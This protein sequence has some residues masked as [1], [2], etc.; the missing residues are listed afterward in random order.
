MSSNQAK[1]PSTVAAYQRGACLLIPDGAKRL[2]DTARKLLK[3]KGN[4][5]RR[6]GLNFS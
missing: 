4:P 1:Q 6:Q 3:A 2:T 5:L